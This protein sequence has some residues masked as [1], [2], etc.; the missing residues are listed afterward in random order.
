VEHS[1]R[2]LFNGGT[3]LLNQGKLREA[4]AALQA[5][6]TSQREP[7]QP[8]ALYNLG[9]VRF[10][11]GTEALKEAAKPGALRERD[12]KALAYGSQALGALDA[13]QNSTE[14]EAMLSAYLQGRG[15]RRELKGALEA[16]KKAMDIFGGTLTRWRRSSGDFKS[17]HELQ[18]ANADAKSNG[19]VVDRHIAELVDEV[20][21]LLQQMQAMAGQRAELLEKMKKLRGKLPEGEMPGPGEGE[22]DEEEDGKKPEQNIAEKQAPS[23]DGQEQQITPED[24][25]RLLE[26]LKLDSNRKLP[27]GD[28]QAGEPKKK[29][30][31]T[32]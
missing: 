9:H 23:R 22:E 15:A 8:P 25:M 10:K 21:Q 19:D 13:A 27:I 7:I 4:E 20:N 31:K 24:A 12:A 30:G 16:V 29:T 11:Q 2:E 17:T 5:A 14:V 32:W 1:P 3:A 28:Q 6:V 18:P 26:T